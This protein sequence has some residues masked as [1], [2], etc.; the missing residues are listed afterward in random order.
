MG[1]PNMPQVMLL[2]VDGKS[3]ATGDTMTS[4]IG[5]VC[6]GKMI[7]G[8]KD[9]GADNDKDRVWADLRQVGQNLAD[10]LGVPMRE[11]AIEMAEDVESGWMWHDALDL[12]MEAAAQKQ[13]ATP[14][15]GM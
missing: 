8:A 14:K 1:S 2:N 9:W 7:Q 11:V 5:I 6:N 3:V 15:I 10:A 13:K 12:G 4:G